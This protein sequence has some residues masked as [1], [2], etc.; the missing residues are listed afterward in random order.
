MT[1][2]K[3]RMIS[4]DIAKGIAILLVVLLHIVEAPSI[5]RTILGLLFGYAMP[6]FLFMS[7]FNYRNEGLKPIEN[8]KRRTIQIIKPFILYTL[9]IAII[10][11][12]HFILNGEATINECIKS[13]LGFLISRWGTP[14]IGW[15]L[16]KTLF[17]R[18]YGPL[19][20]IQYLIP[21]TAIFYL[22]VDKALKSKKNFLITIFLLATLSCILIELGLVLP[23][24]LQDSPAIASIMIIA[25]YCRQD[26]KLFKTPSKKIYT[27][28]NCFVCILTI[29]IIELFYNTAGYVA[30]GEMSSML[31]GFEVYVTQLV[32]LF[33]SYFLINIAMLIE[34][35]PIVSNAYIWLGQHSLQILFL[36]LPLA[37]LV[38]DS[39]GYKQMET[40]YPVAVDKFSLDQIITFIITM[41]LLYIIIT[42]IEKL[43]KKSKSLT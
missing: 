31:G 10:M 32:A 17:Q 8:I 28:L 24:G 4:Q 27:Y 33:G 25:A 23:W 40:E 39:L 22:F 15:D 20:F 41:T 14:Y 18:I 2:K 42:T 6:F 26:N 43:N 9:I 19:W 34:N 13:Y 5:I 29:A 11:S 21:S 36:H 12:F 35:I 30:A 16:P 37:H 1:V 7:G 3:E 38:I